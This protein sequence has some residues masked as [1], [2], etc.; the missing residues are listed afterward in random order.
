MARIEGIAT[1][2]TPVRSGA[3]SL[4]ATIPAWV[5]KRLGLTK[6]DRLDWMLDKQGNV[7]MVKIGKDVESA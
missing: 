3:E 6:D 2:I 1:A 4:R 5:V 7:W